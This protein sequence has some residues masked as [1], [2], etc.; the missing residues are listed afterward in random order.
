MGGGGYPSQRDG[1]GWP[2]SES[3]SLLSKMVVKSPDQEGQI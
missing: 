1:L 2:W 3:V